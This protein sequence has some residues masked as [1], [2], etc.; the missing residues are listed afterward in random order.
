MANFQLPS[1]NTF[2]DMNYYLVLNFGLVTPDRQKAMHKS[3]PCISTGVLKKQK[4]R[5]KYFYD[6]H[7]VP[8]LTKV[9]RPSGRKINK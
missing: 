6:N 4:Q 3:P 7:R 9:M 8:H 5:N 2:R 1:Y